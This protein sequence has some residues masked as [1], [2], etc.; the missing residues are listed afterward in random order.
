MKPGVREVGVRVPAVVVEYGEFFIQPTG[1][2]FSSN[3]TI[4]SKFV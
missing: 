4:Y 3:N 1:K 2:V